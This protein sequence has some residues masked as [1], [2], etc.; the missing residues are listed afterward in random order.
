MTTINEAGIPDELKHHRQWVVWRYEQVELPPKKATKVP[1]SAITGRMASSVDRFTWSTFSDALA[2][3]KSN[4][5]DGIGFVLTRDD[6]YT[7]IDLDE[8]STTEELNRNNE[9][10]YAM[11][12]FT[13]FSP[14]GKG[15]HIWTKAEVAKGRNK[16]PVEIYSNMRFMT[17]TGNV[18]F[19]T[20]I[21][22][23]QEQVTE[24]WTEIAPK[25]AEIYVSYD[26]SD[27]ETLSDQEIVDKAASARNGY[28]FSQ[29]WNGFYEEWYASQ[30]EADFA[31]VD[32]IAF[33]TQNTEQVARL[34]RFSALGK[35]DKALR[36]DYLLPTINK[37][38]DKLPPKIDFAAMQQQTASWV[39]EYNKAQEAAKMPIQVAMPTT[40]NAPVQQ[41]ESTIQRNFSDLAYAAS[42]IDAPYTMPEGLM[43]EMADYIYRSAPRPVKELAI[44]AAIGLMAGIAGN[45]FNVSG[46]GLNVYLLLL[47]QTG[48]G[49]ESVHSGISKLMNTIKPLVPSSE[50]FLGASDIA[51]PQALLKHLATK[52]RCFVSII[53][54]CGMWLKQ[55][56]D[57]NAPA[58]FSG[59]RRLLLALYGRS[60]AGNTVQPSIYAD[61]SKNT[62]SIVSPAVSMLGEST[63]TRFFDMI[64]EDLISEGF[65]PRWTII[66]YAGNRPPHNPQHNTIYPTNELIS[67]LA[68]LCSFCIKQMQSL[69]A[70]NVA[71]S[72]AAKVLIDEFDLFCDTQINGTA[73]DA[74]RDLWTR[75][76]VKALKLAALVAVGKNLSMPMISESDFLWAR[77]I[78]LKDVMRMCRRF[79]SG[80][81]TSRVNQND[82]EQQSKIIDAIK[83]YIRD[84]S[85]DVKYGIK[86]SMRMVN[87]IPYFYLQ[88]KLMN[89]KAFK[90][91]R[92]GAANAM[93][94]AIKNMMMSGLLSEVPEA[95]SRVQFGF[96]GKVY[97]ASDL[98]L[99]LTAS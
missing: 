33:Y 78:V 63:P 28:K 66:E 34:F 46:L 2:F 81:L 88:R 80:L 15:V 77:H 60:G 84:S 23:R 41:Q 19:A 97:V 72:P 16:R 93:Q 26:G 9:I 62:E 18:C 70:T 71:A 20:D 87:A 68:T 56:S 40:E 13:E 32:I 65:I 36:D 17:V 69:Q 12:S 21:E 25:T 35:R 48:T 31:L 79:N 8:P 83:L 1:Y 75:A 55:L 51:S 22:Y 14:S 37:A 73:E 44:G 4:N 49:K 99:L 59:L 42:D 7:V 54:E 47:A 3:Q 6:P 5:F 64:D 74:I 92:R 61:A 39:A 11:A 30:S 50:L 94:S 24:L 90:N 53:G 76:H 27:P 96:S 82:S 85:V 43:G 38:Y 57:N 29:L 89:T 58:H 45:S 91:D 10:F 52:Q 98:D 86:P 95:Q 67:G